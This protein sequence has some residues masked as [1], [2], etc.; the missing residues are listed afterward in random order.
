MLRWPQV[1]RW[2]QWEGE[3]KLGPGTNPLEKATSV[4]EAIAASA[5]YEEWIGQLTD[6]TRLGWLQDKQLYQFLKSRK[7]EHERLSRAVETGVW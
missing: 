2:I 4:E 5:S 1:V 6:A 7:E 3:A